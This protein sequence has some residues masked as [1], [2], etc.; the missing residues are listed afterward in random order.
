MCYV[1][2]PEDFRVC[3]EQSFVC[4]YSIS[5]QRAEEAYL[6]QLVDSTDFE[7]AELER[8]LPLPCIRKT[9]WRKVLAIRG[10]L[11]CG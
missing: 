10:E 4:F 9:K 1:L 6:L 7:S 3:F 2:K 5:A 8:L 11:V